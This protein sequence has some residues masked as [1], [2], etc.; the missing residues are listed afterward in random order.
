M[1]VIRSYQNIVSVSYNFI[2]CHG[3]ISLCQKRLRDIND[4]GK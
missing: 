2:D 4:I 1:H 3:V